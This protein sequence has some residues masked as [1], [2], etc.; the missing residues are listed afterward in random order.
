M[1]YDL[2]KALGFEYKAQPVSWTKKD[3]ITYAV[4]IG[5]TKDDLKFVYE[6]GEWEETTLLFNCTRGGRN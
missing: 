5:A 3:L 6:L 1:S 4:G 2:S